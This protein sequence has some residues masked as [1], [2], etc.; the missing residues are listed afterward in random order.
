LKVPKD[1]RYEVK[2]AYTPNPNRATNVPVTIE[3][4]DGAVKKTVNEREE[5]PIDQSFVSLGTFQFTAEQGAVVVVGNEK[6]DGYVIIDAV[7]LL[8]V[9]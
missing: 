5:P 6:T 3:S 2:F 7:Q 4:A 8:P 1:G 9:R